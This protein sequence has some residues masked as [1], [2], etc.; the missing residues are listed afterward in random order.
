MHLRLFPKTTAAIGEWMKRVLHFLWGHAFNQTSASFCKGTCIAPDT[1]D[2]AAFSKCSGF[3][4]FVCLCEYGAMKHFR[5]TGKHG[6]VPLYRESETPKNELGTSQ[7]EEN[8][9]IRYPLGN[10]QIKPG[11]VRS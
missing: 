5:M 8:G 7:F 4:Q 10:S 6:K 1:D 2:E 3:T 9:A 11:K